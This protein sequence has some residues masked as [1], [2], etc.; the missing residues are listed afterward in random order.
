[1]SRNSSISSSLKHVAK[2]QDYQL[3]SAPP[4]EAL[5]YTWGVEESTCRISLNSLPFHI[6]PNLRD[7]LRRL[8][9][10]SSTRT[11]WID[12]ICINQNNEDEKGVQVP[13]MG[14]IYTRAER[15]IAWLGEET[16]DSGVALDFLPYLAAV[17][18]FDKE[19]IWLLHLETDKF[20]RRMMSL[21]H[22]FS[23]PWWKRM[24]KVQEV[25]L[26]LDVLI[27]CGS[28]RVPWSIFHSSTIAWM[29]IGHE[30]LHWRLNIL[31]RTALR[32][33]GM[34]VSGFAEALTRL[35]QAR[36]MSS[37]PPELLKL[38]NPLWSF[39]YRSVTDPRDKIY[40]LLG[41][42]GDHRVQVDYNKPFEDIYL[43]LVSSFLLE[44]KGLDLFRWMTGEYYETRNSRLPSWVPDFGSRSITPVSSFL[45]NQDVGESQRIFMTAGPDRSRSFSAIQ[46]GDDSRTLILRGCLFDVVSQRGWVY[47]SPDDIGLA[48]RANR[49]ILGRWKKMAMNTLNRTYHSP[50]AK[51]DAF[52]RTILTDRQIEG[53]HFEENAGWIPAQRLP[54]DAQYIPP[55]TTKEE[56][57]LLQAMEKRQLCL[58]S[59]RFCITKKGH[60][61][62]LPPT[63][64]ENDK[65]CVL[66]GGEVPYVLRRTDYQSQG[67]YTMVGECYVHGI[68][69]GEAIT[70]ILEGRNKGD[71]FKLR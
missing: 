31:Q 60:F 48:G 43:S 69:D 9:Q 15:V 26:A 23:R 33:L 40:S 1:M 3:D 62:L 2:L 41:L 17:A 52:W 51:E 20:L 4:Y 8:R 28:R 61:C 47:P 27:L 55:K 42:L 49:P 57:D 7:A 11:V 12:A 44:D 30:P 50:H 58:N 68:M 18:E 65:I 70:D 35:R 45:P 32:T 5:S 13:L 19:S 37:S 71:I 38:S 56:E 6:R 16:F 39:K 34:L 22:L 64:S 54:L 67:T 14:D 59:R 21:V 25:A 36:Q 63:A 53:L 46:F 66:L 10:S 29:N 24:W